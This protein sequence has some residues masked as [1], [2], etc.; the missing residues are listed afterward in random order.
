MSS[1][2]NSSGGDPF[3]YHFFIK[4]VIFFISHVKE[5]IALNGAK[6]NETDWEQGSGF[7]EQ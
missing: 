5:N 1:E 6:R 4:S 2:L 7:N 3:L